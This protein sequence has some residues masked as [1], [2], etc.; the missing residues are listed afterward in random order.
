MGHGAYLNVGGGVL[1]VFEYVSGEGFDY[2]YIRAL[3]VGV[4]SRVLT[5]FSSFS[6]EVVLHSYLNLAASL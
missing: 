2:R 4:R 3:S 6:S 1:L 5:S